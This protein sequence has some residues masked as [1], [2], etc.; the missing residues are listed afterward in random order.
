LQKPGQTPGFFV[1]TRL[2]KRGSEYPS[3]VFS[4]HSYMSFQPD[5]A[6]SGHSAHPL[7]WI[8]EITQFPAMVWQ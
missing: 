5:S 1:S 4:G 3:F 8:K 2:E 6:A 7:P